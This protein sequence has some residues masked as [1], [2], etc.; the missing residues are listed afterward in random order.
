MLLSSIDISLG[1]GDS[2]TDN[3]EEVGDP[4][5]DPEPDPLS[6]SLIE[7][8]LTIQSSVAASWNCFTFTVD[9][10]KDADDAD[11]ADDGDVNDRSRGDSWSMMLITE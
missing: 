2:D 5:L 10:S 7:F 11:D 9:D 1:E 3:D 8:L 6:P 4:L